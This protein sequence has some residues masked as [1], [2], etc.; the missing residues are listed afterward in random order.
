MSITKFVKKIVVLDIFL[1]TALLS[2]LLLSNNPNYIVIAQLSSVLPRAQNTT[3][4]EGGSSSNVTLSAPQARSFD[5]APM[6]VPFTEEEVEELERRTEKTLNRP[7]IGI[8]NE[9]AAPPPNGTAVQLTNQTDITIANQTGNT[10]QPIPTTIPTTQMTNIIRTS[11]STPMPN[12]VTGDKLEFFVNSTVTPSTSRSVVGEPSVAN[13]GS[14]VFYTG[15]WYVARSTDNGTSWR[16]LDPTSDMF[17][18]CCDQDVLYDPRH[19][20]FVWYRQGASEDNTGENR[21]RI[22]VSPDARNW[23]FYNLRPTDLNT[24]WRNQ[25]LDYPHL[26]LS[27]NYLYFT[28]NMFDRDGDF[29]RTIIVRLPLEDLANALVPAAEY[30]IS[31]QVGTFTPVQGA[32]DAMYWAAHIDNAHMALYKWNETLPAAAVQ[33]T[34]SEI[35]LWT[36]EPAVYDCPTP[37]EDDNW[38]A[39]SDDRITNGWVYAD[40]IGFFWNVERGGEFPWPYVNSAVFNAN[41]MTYKGRPLLWSPNFAILYAYTSPNDNGRLGLIATFGGGEIEPS[42]AASINQINENGNLQ[43]WNLVP[44]I[45]GTHSPTDNEWGDY[46]RVRPYNA[47]DDTWIASSYTLQGGPDER[48]SEPRLFIFGVVPQFPPPLASPPSISP[49]SF[50]SETDLDSNKN[51][52][53]VNVGTYTSDLNK[54]KDLT[55]QQQ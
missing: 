11:S 44:I 24:S 53:I 19:E 16:Y 47:T 50:G 1:V 2:V 13:K 23:W 20:V 51:A 26:A 35:P 18:F 34:V 12:N 8:I 40:H 37:R 22:G 49:V 32:T 43:A 48:F 55:E 10:T 27:N 36:F 30:Y 41:N 28:S 25:W 15:N 29:I 45:N 9:T 39:R 33:R 52:E 31:N 46:L 38:C 21:V 3:I 17:D 6:P 4:E 14:T 42:I 54:K 7:Q 5:T